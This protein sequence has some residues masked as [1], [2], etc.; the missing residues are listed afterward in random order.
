MSMP[1]RS[2]SGLWCSYRRL[3]SPFSET[4]ILQ[5]EYL[6]RHIFVSCI[7]FSA[8]TQDSRQP[9]F[10]RWRFVQISRKPFNHMDCEESI[11]FE[12]ILITFPTATGDEA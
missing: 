9:V 11:A 3:A 6:D 7:I 12:A 8:L 4:W 1:I 10:S 5:V 2:R